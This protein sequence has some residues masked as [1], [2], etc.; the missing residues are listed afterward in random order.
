MT[1][2]SPKNGRWD[3]V[4]YFSSRSSVPTYG[5][6]ANYAIVI[7]SKKRAWP[8]QKAVDLRHVQGPCTGE[9]FKSRIYG[10]P[11]VSVVH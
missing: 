11:N 2:Q 7:I 1:H 9:L 4:N 5:V 10:N 3:G 8:K 6:S